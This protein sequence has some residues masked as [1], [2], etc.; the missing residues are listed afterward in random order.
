MKKIILLFTSITALAN[1]ALAQDN[2]TD[3]RNRFLFGIKAGANYSNV[4]DSQSQ[5]FKADPKV[6]F[7]GGAFL[8][9]PIGKFLG[10]Q[11]EILYS[12]KGFQATGTFLGS[13]YAFTRT[14]TYIDVP[15]LFAL[16]A[17]EFFTILAG[18]QYSYLTKQK[19][20]FVNS[21][22]SS[23]QETQ[24]QNE[25][26]RKNTLCVTGGLDITMKHIVLSGR[27][28]WDIQNNNGNGTSTTPRYKN[29]WYQATVGYRFYR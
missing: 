13:P 27:A 8:S 4:Y 21:D 16:K 25:N 12:Q 7:A 29:M 6:G 24:F 20:T 10:L 3:L 5:D 18:P 23:A 28:G 11:P 14:T 2:T 17:S 1:T 9:I 26:L 19:D 15:V 22:A